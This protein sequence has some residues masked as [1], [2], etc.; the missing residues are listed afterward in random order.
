MTDVY[1]CIFVCGTFWS[2]I[3]LNNLLT[4]HA[5]ICVHVC[6]RLINLTLYT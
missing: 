5:C 2:V 1:I 3:K 6:L 4:E